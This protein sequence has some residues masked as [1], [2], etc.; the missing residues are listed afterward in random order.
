MKDLR[1]ELINVFGKVQGVFFRK[2]TQEKANKIGL[3]PEFD[4][5]LG[6][7]PLINSGL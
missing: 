5:K 6:L 1:A 7:R 3:K 2:S 4:V